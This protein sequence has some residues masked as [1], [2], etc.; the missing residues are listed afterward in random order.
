MRSSYELRDH[1]AAYAGR[2]DYIFR[3]IKKLRTRPPDPVPIAADHDDVPLLRA[4]TELL[5]KTCHRAG[6]DAMAGCA[7]HP[8]RKDPEINEKA[9]ADALR[10]RARGE[11]WLHGTWSRPRFGSDRKE[12]STAILGTASEGKDCGRSPRRAPS[13]RT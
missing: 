3:L 11:G 13:C 8:Q 6:G 1:S 12:S 4:Y 7:V 5:V 10:Q 9:S 2:W